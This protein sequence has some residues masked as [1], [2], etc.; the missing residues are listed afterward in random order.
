MILSNDC[1]FHTSSP[2]CVVKFERVGNGIK[3]KLLFFEEDQNNYKLQLGVFEV[4]LTSA[5]P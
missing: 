1:L 4:N 3:E 5:V 2:T